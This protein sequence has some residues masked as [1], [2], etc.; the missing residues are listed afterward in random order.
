VTKDQCKR[1][2]KHALWA[3]REIRKYQPYGR[4]IEK[5]ITQLHHRAAAMYPEYPSP[6]QVRAQY[7]GLLRRAANRRQEILTHPGGEWRVA[8]RTMD[9]RVIYFAPAGTPARGR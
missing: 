4:T 9:G 6:E 3:A 7:F 2:M 5:G 8:G 1:D